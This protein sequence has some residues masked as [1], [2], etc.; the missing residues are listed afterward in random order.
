M[1]NSSP[2][3][4]MEPIKRYPT[5]PYAKS[6]PPNS[7][8]R[9]PTKS[10][11]TASPGPYAPGFNPPTVQPHTPPTNPYRRASSSSKRSSKNHSP[12]KNVCSSAVAR[13]EM[14]LP[15][16]EREED[17]IFLDGGG[18]DYHAEYWADTELRKIM[19]EK[20]RYDD[21]VDAEQS[22]MYTMN[23][24]DERH[25]EDAGEKSLKYTMNG[26]DEWA[27]PNSDEF[28]LPL[29]DQ[30]SEPSLSGDMSTPV[31]KKQTTSLKVNVK[32]TTVERGQTTIPQARSFYVRKPPPVIDLS[33]SESFDRE[34]AEID[35]EKVEAAT[36]LTIFTKRV[37]IESRGMPH[38][39]QQDTVNLGDSSSRDENSDDSEDSSSYASTTSKDS[40]DRDDSFIVDSDE[41]LS[42]GEESEEDEDD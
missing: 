41:S 32:S 18:R 3:T 28:S 20:E 40:Y 24:Y 13:K 35:I 25:D 38:V 26:Y 9:T 5:N 19:A 31:Q 4:P 34:M 23:G 14:T 22:L 1:V 17:M 10:I 33:K 15:A 30:I 39:H 12:G 36:N 29:F 11:Y 37:E 8:P 6:P 7:Q 21:E 27:S 16:V 42:Y 2:K